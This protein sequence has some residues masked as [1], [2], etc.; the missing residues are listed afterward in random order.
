[1]R[2]LHPIVAPTL[3]VDYVVI[4]PAKAAMSKAAALFLA[5]IEVQYRK[6]KELW[7]A[8]GAIVAEVT[9]HPD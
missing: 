2:S 8:T 5:G 7:L 4:E 3:T 9:H 6:L 1:M